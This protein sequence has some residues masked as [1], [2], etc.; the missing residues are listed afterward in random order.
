VAEDLAVVAAELRLP[1]RPE[2]AHADAVAEARALD[3]E[4][5][6]GGR[7]GGHG[8]RG[9]EDDGGDESAHQAIGTHDPGKSCGARRRQGKDLIGSRGSMT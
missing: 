7:A 2:L 9:C 5:L 3:D 1:H 8:E 6:G 4:A